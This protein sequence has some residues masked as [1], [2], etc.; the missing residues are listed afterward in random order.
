M[1]GNKCWPTKKLFEQRIEV[2]ELC[3]LRWMCR[4]TMMDRIK[5][6]GVERR[7]QGCLIIVKDARK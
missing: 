5:R 4:H 6:L 1:Y 7:A 2:V 3:M